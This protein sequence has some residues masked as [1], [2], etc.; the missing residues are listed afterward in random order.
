MI[1]WAE[2]NTRSTIWSCLAAHA[3]VLHLDGIERQRLDA[4]CSGVYDCS[5]AANDWLTEECLP[6]PLKISHSR[7]NALAQQRSGRARLSRPDRIARR[8]ASISSP[9]S[10]AANSSSFRAIP[11]TTPVAA[12]RISARHHPV[13][14][15]SAGCLSRL[16]AA[17]ST[18][19]PNTGSRT[20]RSGRR[21]ERKVPLSAE[22]PKLTLRPDIAAG[23]AAS[24]IFGN[25]LDI[26]PPARPPAR[27]EP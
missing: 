13:S 25:W 3:A 2:A 17:I 24:A 22:L 21:I 11:N 1:D 7:F 14:R 15:G 18:P 6:S 19:K 5:R 20:S 10:C 26:F 9:S 4:K 27:A 23:V 12:A 16:P 8:P